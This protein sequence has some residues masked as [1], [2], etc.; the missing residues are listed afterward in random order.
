VVYAVDDRHSFT[1][2]VGPVCSNLTLPDAEVVQPG[3][4]AD[5]EDRIERTI[6][7]PDKIQSSSEE[8]TAL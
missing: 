7:L 2:F 3:L 8:A 5:F 4:P 1:K 6:V